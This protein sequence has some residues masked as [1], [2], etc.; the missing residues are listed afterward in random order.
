[1]L[2][3]F[4][5]PIRVPLA[6]VSA[7]GVETDPWAALRGIRA[8]GTGIPGVIAYG[9]RRYAGGRDFALVRGRARAVRVDL[10]PGARYGRLLV[11]VPD[12]PATADRIEAALRHARPPA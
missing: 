3:A 4:S 10:D 9:T 2:G 1:M 6:S 11:T 8:P 7:V 5:G 12:P